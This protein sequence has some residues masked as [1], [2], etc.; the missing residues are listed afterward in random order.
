MGFLPACECISQFVKLCL[1]NLKEAK[2]RLASIFS[3]LLVGVVS[4]TALAGT[5]DLALSSDAAYPAIYRGASDRID[6][7]IYNEAPAGSDAGNYSVLASFPYGDAPAHTGTKAADGGTAFITESFTYDS[8]GQPFGDNAIKVKLTDTANN[9][10]LTQTVDVNVLDHARP[11]FVINGRVVQL[12]LPKPAAAVEPSVDPLAF[13]ATGGGEQFAAGAPNVV[14]DP[15]TAVPTGEMDLDSITAVGAPQIT[16]TLNPFIDL[17]ANDDPASGKPFNVIVDGTNPGHYET[18]FI[19]N[20]SDEQDLPGAFPP[21]SEQGAFTVVAD[22][23]TGG[24]TGEIIVPEPACVSL[25]L[26]AAS[27]TLAHRRRNRLG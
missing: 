19:L 2:M 9:D 23:T 22:V 13:G 26:L 10:Q 4:C 7:M 14:A 6:A 5:E 16:I 24:V 17:V 1:T 25:T 8:T 12:P 15:L 20:Y 21:G 11:A 27:A 3:C 18:Q